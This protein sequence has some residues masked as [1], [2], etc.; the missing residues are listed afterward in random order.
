MSVRSLGKKGVPLLSQDLFYGT[1]A[2]LP[3]LPEESSQQLQDFS[4]DSR[5]DV[6]NTAPG[7][8]IIANAVKI[9][10]G[11][12]CVGP[13][14]GQF[15]WMMA[16]FLADALASREIFVGN[17]DTFSGRVLSH[18]AYIWSMR[19]CVLLHSSKPVLRCVCACVRVFM[20]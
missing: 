4:S 2:A 5:F 6:R 20:F 12:R 14:S 17:E 19:A 8:D 3:A 7:P 16:A 18:R 9:I 10:K 11:L 1:W 13:A 15:V